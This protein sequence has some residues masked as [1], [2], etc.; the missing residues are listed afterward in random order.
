MQ[1]SAISQTNGALDASRRELADLE[2]DLRQHQ[3]AEHDVDPVHLGRLHERRC[4]RVAEG[5]MQSGPRTGH[6]LSGSHFHRNRLKH[7]TTNR[8][9]LSTVALPSSAK[10]ANVSSGSH[11]ERTHELCSFARNARSRVAL[12]CRKS[13]RARWQNLW[14]VKFDAF[15]ET[16]HY[17]LI[18]LD[19]GEGEEILRHRCEMYR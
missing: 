6:W 18:H 5:C 10:S 19:L 11:P 8:R 4:R 14:F 12:S 13:S 7:L 2:Q 1:L 15:S 9:P 3:Q 17:S 16:E